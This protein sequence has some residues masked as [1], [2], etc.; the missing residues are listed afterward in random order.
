M[1]EADNSI[2]QTHCRDFSLSQKRNGDHCDVMEAQRGQ[3][4]H[5]STEFFRR[6]HFKLFRAFLGFSLY[7]LKGIFFGP[8][9]KSLINGLLG[10]VVYSKCLFFNL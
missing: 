6:H 2:I 9:F 3:K 7:R 8:Y 10:R 1:S 5:S 4:R